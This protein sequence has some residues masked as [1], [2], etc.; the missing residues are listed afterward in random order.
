MKAKDIVVG[1]KYVA[2]V[3][4]KLANVRVDAIHTRQS[5]FGPTARDQT[6]YDV[7]NLTTGRKTTFRSAA[8]FR[9]VAGDPS[10]AFEGRLKRLAERGAAGLITAEEQDRQHAAILADER[11]RRGKEAT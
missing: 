9:R 1:G 5:G 3:S 6:V 2:K 7:T 11:Q 10:G 4:G 8:K